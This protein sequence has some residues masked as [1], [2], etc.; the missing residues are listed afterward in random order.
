[1]LLDL[2]SGMSQRSHTD[3]S[4]VSRFGFRGWEAYHARDPKPS[5]G[6]RESSARAPPGAAGGK[7]CNLDFIDNQQPERR[8][9]VETK[10]SNMSPAA[11]VEKGA[12]ILAA[13][14]GVN[15]ELI[16]ARLTK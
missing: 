13:A 5:A 14:Q 3:W 12:A 4:R 8:T 10:K 11:R 7:E 9:V 16:T 1:M 2:R 6:L 15:T